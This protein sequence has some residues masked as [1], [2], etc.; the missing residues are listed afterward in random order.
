ME[1]LLPCILKIL[2]PAYLKFF[3]FFS[4]LFNF[5]DLDFKFRFYSQKLNDF[6]KVIFSWNKKKKN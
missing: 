3:L 1:H 6:I 2:I 5:N 4:F